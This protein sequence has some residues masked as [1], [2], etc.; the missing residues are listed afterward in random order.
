MVLSGLPGMVR[1][2]EPGMLTMRA[3]SLYPSRRVSASLSLLMLVAL[4][5][6]SPAAIAAEGL[7]ASESQ[8]QEAKLKKL[9]GQIAQLK[10]QLEKKFK[11]RD[12][13]QGDL[14]H[15]EKKI[16]L[17]N[18]KLQE[19]DKNL[20]AQE[21]HLTE[22]RRQEAEQRELLSQHKDLLS[23][24]ASMAYLSGRE[25]YL[26]LML[27]QQEPA[28]ISRVLQYYRYF[29]Q[30]RASEMQVVYV[31]L[32]KF[33][34]LEQEISKSANQLA[35]TRQG[36]VL[37]KQELE[38]HKQERNLLLA[39]L[40]KQI[41]QDQGQLSTWQQDE[42]QLKELLKGLTRYLKDIPREV[43]GKF[44]ARSG[45]MEWPVKG[46][47]IA[48]FGQ[49][50][51]LDNLRWQ[52][53]LISAAAGTSVTAIHH[54]RVAFSDWLRGFGQLLIIDHGDGYMSL[55]GY[56]QKLLKETGEWVQAGEAIAV[57]GDSGGQS[58]TGLYF[59]VRHNGKPKNPAAWCRS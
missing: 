53:V 15:A 10:K 12:G 3:L 58:Q 55:Y 32:Q 36:I 18:R 2:I 51:G 6:I 29:H 52:G 59:E 33:L 42:K 41:Q 28:S 24:Q 54:G 56:N 31:Q 44:S 25:E 30:A 35:E 14:E 11:Q 49:A 8:G 13:L 40:H 7:S 1:R 17:E 38:T 37:R 16:L 45:A 22:L 5:F 4:L 27:N 21:Q 39:K 20:V 19:L 34:V 46:E 26:K 50:R 47:K 23:K 43:G 48:R 9:S 57:V